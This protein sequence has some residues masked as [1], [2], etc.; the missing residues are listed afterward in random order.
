MPDVVVTVPRGIW[1]D[2][3]AE[4]DAAGEPASG[5]EWGYYFSTRPMKHL[6][7][8]GGMPTISPGERVYV[9]AHGRL[10]GYALLTR[11]VA[12]PPCLCRGG[13]AVAVTIDEAIVGFPGWRY[14]WWPR[15]AEVPFPGWRSPGATGIHVPGEGLFAP[16]GG[17]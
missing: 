14:R 7:V 8:E 10:R 13:G 3:I 16:R 11:L 2:W 5:E 4:G 1:L 17:E 9:V 15:E 12:R 6:G